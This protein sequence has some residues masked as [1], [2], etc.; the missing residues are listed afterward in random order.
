[1]PHDRLSVLLEPGE[2]DDDRVVSVDAAGISWRDPR[3]TRSR[4][5]WPT[6]WAAD[7]LLLALD[8]STAQVSVA[9]GDGGAVLGS[10]ELTG[11]RRH[12]EQLAP[13]IQYLRGECGVDLD[14]ARRHRGRDRARASSPACGSASPPPR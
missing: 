3:A 1:M 2:G 7:V 14:H 8:T 13:A 5:R 4:L 9:F 12:A 10:V 6:A 11:G